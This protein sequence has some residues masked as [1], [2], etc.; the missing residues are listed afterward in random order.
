LIREILPEAP[1]ELTDEVVLIL[2]DTTEEA[3]RALLEVVPVE[4]EV[5]IVGSWAEK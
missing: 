4:A 5:V 3:G 1:I 2:N